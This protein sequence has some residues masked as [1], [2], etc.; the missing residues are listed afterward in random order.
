MAETII[1]RAATTDEDTLGKILLLVDG[2]VRGTET[3]VAKE[4][5][6]LADGSA[7]TVCQ[8]PAG[9]RNRGRA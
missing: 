2:L 5:P 6:P 8:L 3:P 7:T 4:A 9:G 1:R